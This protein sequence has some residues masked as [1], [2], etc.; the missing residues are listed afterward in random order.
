MIPMACRYEARPKG[1]RVLI[2][3]YSY[4]LRQRVNR[5]VVLITISDIS[6]YHLLPNSCV[7]YPEHPT[8]IWLKLL[9]NSCS[10]TSLPAMKLVKMRAATKN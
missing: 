7:Y 9:T 3:M 2:Y 4:F 6:S 1:S 10:A 8:I 5:G